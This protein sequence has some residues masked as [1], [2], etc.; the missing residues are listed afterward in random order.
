MVLKYR[1]YHDKYRGMHAR[2]S[3]DGNFQSLRDEL[4]QKDD[5]LLRV[6]GRC[7]ELEGALRA[8]EHELDVRR[9]LRLSVST[10]RLKWHPCETRLSRV[11]PKPMP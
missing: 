5:E 7:N 4:G 9:G 2:F 8:K 6:T 1:K 3:V 11:R 10:F